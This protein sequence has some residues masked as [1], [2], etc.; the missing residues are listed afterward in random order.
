[1]E[2]RYENIINMILRYFSINNI[3]VLN[4]RSHKEELYIILLLL[5]NQGVFYE[6][7]KIRNGD[8]NSL[9]NIKRN[10]NKAEEKLLI[11]SEFRKRYYKIKES[12]QEIMWRKLINY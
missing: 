6:N 10:L 2:E 5:D 8:I 12:L 3:S 11:N 4:E 1:M 7:N 9:K